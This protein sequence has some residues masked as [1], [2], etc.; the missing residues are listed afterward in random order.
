[1]KTVHTSVLLHEAIDTLNLKKGDVFVDGTFGGGGHSLYVCE[2]L[3][4]NIQIIGFDQDADALARAKE[5]FTKCSPTLINSNY[6]FIDEK[7]QEKGIE[8]VNGIL[9][10]IGFS[11]DQ[12][13]NSNRGFSFLR[14]EPLLMTMISN[15]G[16]DAVTAYTIVNEWSEETIADIIYGY[17]EERFARHIARGIMT[18]RLLGPIETTFDLVEIIKSSV[19]ISYTKR[20]IHP[21]TKTF[22]ALRIAVNDELG[23]LKDGLEK[24]F[25]VL[26]KN[27]RFGVISFHSMEDRIVKRFMKEK[28]VTGEGKRITKKPIIPAYEEIKRNPRARSAKLRVI[29]KTI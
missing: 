14:D 19:P 3:G 9:F 6:R 23:A 16:N 12:L 11:S 28:E 7:L 4:K 20:R 24:G 27:G 21:A 29:E 22:Q 2:Q 13:E 17:G 18:A 26:G 15:P 10:D 1:M 25:K 5:L 8:S